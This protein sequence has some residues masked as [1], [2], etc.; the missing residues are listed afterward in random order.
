[1]T[2]AAACAASGNT[3]PDRLSIAVFAGKVVSVEKG[4]TTKNNLRGI[5]K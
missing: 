1:M 3:A 2:D 4:K 5:G